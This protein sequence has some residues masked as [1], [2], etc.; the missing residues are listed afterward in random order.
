MLTNNAMLREVRVVTINCTTEPLRRVACRRRR[1]RASFFVQRAGM[2][3][4]YDEAK[5]LE[6]ILKSALKGRYSL[7]V[8]AH[9]FANQAFLRKSN[10]S[11]LSTLEHLIKRVNNYVANVLN[12]LTR[13]FLNDSTRKEYGH[14]VNDPATNVS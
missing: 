1:Y 10:Y 8:L 9:S 12:I 6:R 4:T 2:T 13:F 5:L 14:E 3:I 7:G 11:V